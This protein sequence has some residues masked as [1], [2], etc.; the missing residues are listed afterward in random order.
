MHQFSPVILEARTLIGTSFLSFHAHQ[1]LS[2]KVE[3]SLIGLSTPEDLTELWAHPSQTI[4]LGSKSS[5]LCGQLKH[6]V[7]ITR[8]NWNPRFIKTERKLAGQCTSFGTWLPFLSGLWMSILYF[9]TEQAW[10]EHQYLFQSVLTV[11]WDFLS[12]QSS[13][14]ALD[15]LIVPP[16]QTSTWCPM[17]MFQIFECSHILPISCS[18]TLLYFL[19]LHLLLPRL[20]DLKHNLQNESLLAKNLKVV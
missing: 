20:V 3:S 11:N 6:M 2:S 4:S 14:Y 9:H 15:P 19:L 1:D 10:W 7:H 12:V 17:G 5:I 18:P 16:T 13:Y 8:E